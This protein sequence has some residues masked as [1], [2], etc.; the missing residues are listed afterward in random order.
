MS[1]LVAKVYIVCNQT[2]K[3]LLVPISQL[4]TETGERLTKKHLRDGEQVIFK[5]TDHKTYAVSIK[6][7][8]HG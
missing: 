7:G 3:T 8:S 4:S 6:T 2:G 5:D 1:F